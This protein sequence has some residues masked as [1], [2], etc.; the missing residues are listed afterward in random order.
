MATESGILLQAHGII[1]IVFHDFLQRG[2]LIATEACKVICQGFV[3][4]SSGQ[5]HQF[6]ELE[7]NQSDIGIFRYGKVSVEGVKIRFQLFITVD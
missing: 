5:E 7:L 1:K 6:P 2:F 3:G 4:G